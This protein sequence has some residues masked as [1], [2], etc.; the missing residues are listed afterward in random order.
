MARNEA[1]SKP[2]VW[3][4]N[5]CGDVGA[6]SREHLIHVAIGRVILGN[7][8][9]SKDEVRAGLQSERFRQFGLYREPSLSEREGPAWSNQSIRGLICK[10]CNETWAKEL[11]EE[12]GKA[13]FGFI[14]GGEPAQ[15]AL[16]RRWAWYF[17]IK[18]WW[19]NTRTETLADGPLQPM[20][21]QIAK[22][23]AQVV[24]PMLVRVVRLPFKGEEWDFAA[25]VRGWAGVQ[26]SAFIPWVMRGVAMLAVCVFG[27]TMYL[28]IPDS[29]E[30]TQGL[31]LSAVPTLK[32]EEVPPLFTAPPV[33]PGPADDPSA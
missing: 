30:L 11:E 12:A 2:D 8:G 29:A 22:P 17:A 3:T 18:L 10:E 14:N 27:S 15:A 28:P 9:L 4:C 6:T 32:P 5:A 23:D 26:E 13:L 24:S 16:L 21:A 7:A 33:V 20:L 25:N 31:R 19:A 1:T